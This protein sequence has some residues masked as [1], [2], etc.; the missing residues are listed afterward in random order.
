[1]CIFKPPKPPKPEKQPL[2]QTQA[3]LMRRDELARAGTGSSTTNNTTTPLGVPT[4]SV[5]GKYLTA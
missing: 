5:T 4:A 2:S 3:Y 1:M